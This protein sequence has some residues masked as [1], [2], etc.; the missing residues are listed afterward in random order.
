MTHR[1]D[2][3]PS[4]WV[5]VTPS[6]TT[7]VNLVGFYVGTTGNVAAQS[8]EGATVIF[9]AVPAGQY[10]PGRFVRIMSAS[11]TASDIVGATP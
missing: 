8:V 2:L 5:T 6:D 1:N 10:I 7:A 11:T 3:I 4:A 9:K